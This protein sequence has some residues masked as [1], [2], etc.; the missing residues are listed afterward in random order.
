MSGGWATIIGSVVGAVL[1]VSGGFF[2][3]CFE[4]TRKTAERRKV[5]AKALHFEVEQLRHRRGRLSGTSR[6]RAGYPMSDIILK[7]IY[8]VTVQKKHNLSLIPRLRNDHLHIPCWKILS[9]E[10]SERTDQM[11]TLILAGGKIGRASCRERV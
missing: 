1:A 7:G 2:F 6:S 8:Y 10:I 9:T 5:V 4:D 3:A 11:K